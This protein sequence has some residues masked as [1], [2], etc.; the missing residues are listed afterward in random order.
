VNEMADL[1]KKF[2]VDLLLLHRDIASF[3]M[4]GKIRRSVPDSRIFM[5][6][7]RPDPQEGL[8]FLQYGV[9]GYANSH[10]AA[11]LL[12]EAVHALMNGSVWI[13]Q[14]LIQLLIQK[15]SKSDKKNVQGKDDHSGKNA[16]LAKLSDRELEITNLVGQGLSNGEIAVRL[17]ITERTVK[18][19][20]S[21]V[22]RKT[23]SSGRLGL[24][25]LVNRSG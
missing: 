25:L 18:A 8:E 19:H 24:A 10:I 3:E 23:G 16:V 2:R 15:S 5:L 20:L 14:D 6:S 21:S 4:V 7:N 1:S 11:G 12:V 13:S 17:D 22:Y 9:V